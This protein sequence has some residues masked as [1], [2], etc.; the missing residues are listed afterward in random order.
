[1]GS[2]PVLKPDGCIEIWLERHKAD[3]GCA[4]ALRSL[5]EAI[6]TGWK[7]SIESQASEEAEE[8]TSGEPA[9]TSPSK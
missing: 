4:G 2:K 5:A 9:L 8:A 7:A 6:A 1:L 3:T